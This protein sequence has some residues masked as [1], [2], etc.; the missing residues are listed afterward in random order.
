MRVSAAGAA[1]RA[2]ALFVVPHAADAALSFPLRLAAEREQG[3]VLVAVGFGGVTESSGWG[4]R[5]DAW[6]CEWLTLN[7]P[8]ASERDPACATLRGAVFAPH[9]GEAE[10]V[11]DLARR[12]EELLRAAKP[13][14]VYLPLAVGEHVDHRIC[15]A[16]G[17]RAMRLFE[18]TNVFLYE[19]RPQVLWPGA[20]RL[21]L[22]A[23]GAR[24]PPAARLPRE[25]GLVQ[26]W[27]RQPWAAWLPCVPSRLLDRLRCLGPFA[28]RRREASRWRPQKALGPRLQPV[29]Q[30]DHPAGRQLAAEARGHWLAES[31]RSGWTAARL[32]GW[33][34]R[35]DH[36]ANGERGAERLWL[37]LPE[38]GEVPVDERLAAV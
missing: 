14:S 33:T 36:G 10:L 19:E 27:L 6:G 4:Q 17:L 1:S 12:L 9:A 34:A 20:A 25:A 13:A 18:G 26:G 38:K 37:V 5:F 22:G 30:P 8:A 32:Q 31:A 23:L 3:R 29:L 2:A 7:L 15:H 16:A 28:R 21:R 11:T 35:H 24:L